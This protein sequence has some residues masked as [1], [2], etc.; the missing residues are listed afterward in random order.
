MM[1]LPIIENSIG[2]L[3]IKK[4]EAESDFVHGYYEKSHKPIFF[5]RA[6]ISAGSISSL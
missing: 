6:L 4:Q 5:K 3:F 2:Y 1:L